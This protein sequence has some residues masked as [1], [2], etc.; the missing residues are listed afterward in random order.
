MP[1]LHDD[2]SISV[3]F[4]PGAF[5][6]TRQEAMKAESPKSARGC[7]EH[8]ATDSVIKAIHQAAENGA[9]LDAIASAAR[10]AE[11]RRCARIEKALRGV[12]DLEI[13][14]GTKARR[15]VLAY[16][17]QGKEHLVYGLA[18]PGYD[19]KEEDAEKDAETGIENY[20]VQLN[21]L[22]NHYVS[23]YYKTMQSLHRSLQDG[24]IPYVI[25]Y[26]DK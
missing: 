15:F 8:P 22:C 12:V 17:F 1:P 19:A 13:I 4:D 18:Y 16:F 23:S 10:N 9:D 21:A 5:Q 26:F 20:T 3:T 25:D 11:A 2:V 24:D 14:K 6:A 7:H